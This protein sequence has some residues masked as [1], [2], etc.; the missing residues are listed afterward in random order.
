MKRTLVFLSIIIYAFKAIAQTNGAARTPDIMDKVMALKEYK[1]EEEKMNQWQKKTK[2]NASVIIRIIRTMTGN[3]THS[4]ISE[5]DIIDI[6]GSK[7]AK[8]YIILFHEKNDEI[9]SVKKA[10]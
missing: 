7:R 1:A 2:E 9:I 3:N 10:R 8:T 6:K 5:A 4:D